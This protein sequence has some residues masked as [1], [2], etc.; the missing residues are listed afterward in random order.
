M[1]DGLDWLMQP[2]LEGFCLYSEL[3]DGTLDLLDVAIM[4]DAI[5]V[6]DEN[7]YRA[8]DWIKKHGK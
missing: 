6:R 8:Q 2:V 5:L 4:N 3:K 1:G 7:R